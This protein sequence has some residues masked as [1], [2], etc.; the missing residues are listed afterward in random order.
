MTATTLYLM[1]IPDFSDYLGRSKP[2]KKNLCFWSTKSS[3]TFFFLPFLSCR[4]HCDFQE[5]PFLPF[6]NAG[7]CPRGRKKG[8][9]CVAYLG[10]CRVVPGC[11]HGACRV[12]AMVSYF[13]LNFLLSLNG[14]LHK[15]KNSNPL[16][17]NQKKNPTNLTSIAV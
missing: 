6:D 16:V 8:G 14:K 12:L 5:D 13:H 4:L 10:A 11:V 17:S 2:L 3:F 1:I 15:R 7:L 9:K